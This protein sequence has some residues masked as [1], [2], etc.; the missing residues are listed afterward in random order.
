MSLAINSA[1]LGKWEWKVIN[2]RNG[3]WFDA[4]ANSY[5]ICNGV[6]SPSLNGAS[7]WWRDIR[8][9]D[10][11]RWATAREYSVKEVYK[12]LEQEDHQARSLPWCKIWIKAIPSNVSCL[13]WRVLQ[14]RI[15]TKDNLLKRGVLSNSQL[16]CAG[17]CGREE[18]V[19]HLFFECPKIAGLWMLMCNWLGVTTN[20]HIEGWQHLVQFEG[21]LGSHRNLI[22][23]MRVLW[24]ACVWCIWR[25]RNNKV[26]RR[27]EIQMEKLFEESKITAW[28]WLKIKSKYIADD[29]AA[30][31]KNP[32][33]CFGIIDE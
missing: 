9:L 32:K 16:G 28:R 5:G 33:A 19:S 1:L 13:V 30:W 29:I 6:L 11:G 18:S 27:E 23:K 20:L 3:I 21:L 24:A 2:E 31:C 7:I 26:F 12:S 25:G 10:I 14:N 15:P 22:M 4:L 8:N 17:E